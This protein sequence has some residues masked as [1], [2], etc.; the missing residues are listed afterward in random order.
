MTMDVI[1][2][3]SFGKSIDA[4][5]EPN[6][7]APLI[8]A[9]DVSADVFVRFKHAD[10]YKNMIMNCPPKLSKILSPATAGL[11]DLQQ[12]HNHHFLCL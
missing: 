5:E 2:Y 4:I 8:K 7:A 6:F 3:L 9:M 10:W 12:V 11:V 1:T